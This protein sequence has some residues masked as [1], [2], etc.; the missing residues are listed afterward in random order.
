M[1]VLRF[2]ATVF[3]IVAT[4]A[5]AG[6]ITPV[7]D[8]AGGFTPTSLL[9]HLQDFAPD[10]M[11]TAKAAV[12]HH[13]APWVWDVVVAGFGAIPTFAL[14]GGLALASGY[15]GRHRR[16]GVSPFAN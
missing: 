14:F 9:G 12:S 5:F 3:L 16:I 10:T 11:Q 8:G 15:F 4:I 1:L 2:L 7:L 6:D 13:T